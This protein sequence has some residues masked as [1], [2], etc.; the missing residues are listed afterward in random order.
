MAQV[1]RDSEILIIIITSTSSDIYC[2]FFLNSFVSLF[3]SSTELGDGI[4]CSPIKI[5][6]ICDMAIITAQKYLTKTLEE[7]DLRI[8]NNVH[9]RITGNFILVILLNTIYNYV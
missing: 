2:V 8:K 4:L 7:I 3:E 1:H 6:P 9:V 5:L